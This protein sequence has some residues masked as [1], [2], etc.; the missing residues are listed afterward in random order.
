MC[1]GENGAGAVTDQTLH[2]TTK[3]NCST[4]VADEAFTIE[5]RH[6]WAPVGAERFV[7]LVRGEFF[8][9]IGFFRC[10]ANFLVQ[11]GI[12]SDVD[13]KEYWQKQ[14]PIQDDVSLHI[15]FKR[16]M[17]SF[18]GSGPNSRTTQVFI[19]FKDLPF[20]G[21]SVWET[22]IGTVTSGMDSVVDKLYSGYGDQAGF[23]KG[24]VNQGRLQ[25]EGNS[26]LR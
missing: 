19:T 21:K 4:T 8:T 1:L 13:I 3:I 15:P 25:R 6:D 9:D 14:G 17:V 10:V 26:Y 11:F 5:V 7:N 22:P 18:A 23:N 16:G 2:P 24:G 20:L 12:S